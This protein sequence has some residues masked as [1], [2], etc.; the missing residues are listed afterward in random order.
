MEPS[1]EP[2]M[3][4]VDDRMASTG[5]GKKRTAERIKILLAQD[6]QV[7]EAAYAALKLTRNLEELIYVHPIL[8]NMTL[9]QA[10]NCGMEPK[11]QSSPPTTSFQASSSPYLLHP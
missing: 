3:A 1:Q 2:L 5:L 9:Q 8:H 7:S 4:T 11:N 6:M 10:R